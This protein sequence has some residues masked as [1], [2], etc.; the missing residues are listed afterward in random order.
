MSPERLTRVSIGIFI[1][2]IAALCA[3]LFFQSDAEATRHCI[4][5]GYSEAEC[6]WR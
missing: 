1:A 6:G 5:K 4:E 3:V 2:V